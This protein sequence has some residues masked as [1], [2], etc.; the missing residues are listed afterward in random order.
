[1]S[2]QSIL[3]KYRN[4]SYS[5]R[6][7]G[8]R[9]EELISR[10]L[11]TDPAY[12]SILEKVWAWSTFP[13]RSDFGGRDAGIDLVGKTRDGEYWAFQCK[14]YAENHSVTK[15]DMDTFLSTSGRRFHDTDGKE[16]SFSLRVI[17]ATT[18]NW[19]INAVE[20]TKGQTIPVT[21]IGLSI[22]ENAPVDW[23]EI[24]AG[25]HG[26]DAR[27]KVHELRNHQMEALEAALVH[28]RDHNRGKMIM[29]CGTG[30][31][32]TSLRI[33]EAILDGDLEV[34]E[35]RPGCVLFLAPSISLVG[36]TLREWV[37]NSVNE[38]NAICVCSD[39]TVTKKRTEDDVGERVEDLGLP[40][41]TDPGKIAFRA[42]V[43]KDT[44]VVFSTYQSIDAV[45]AAQQHGLPEFDLIICDEAHRTTGV[46]ID[47]QDESSFTKVH[48]NNLLRS[49]RRLYM[50][51][52]PRL[53][54]EKGKADAKRAAVEICSMD[55]ESKYGREF[56][57]LN[58]GSAVEKDLLS[59]Y[60]VLILTTTTSDIPEILKR[61]W[62]DWKGEI[63]TDTNCKIWGCLN[64]LA[65]NVAYDTTLK[66]TDPAPMRS[67]AASPS[68]ACGR[69]RLTSR[70]NGFSRAPRPLRSASSTT[71]T[72]C[73][74]PT[75]RWKSTLRKAPF[76]PARASSTDCISSTST[77]RLKRS[78][79]AF[80]IP[81]KRTSSSRA[82]S[83]AS[84]SLQP[85]C[86]RGARTRRSGTC[87]RMFPTGLMSP[88]PFRASTR[89]FFCPSVSA[90][91]LIRAA[92][93]RRPTSS[94]SNGW[95]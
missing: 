49:K 73:A 7:K 34:G 37:S 10:Y 61:H 17:V 27:Q 13:S 55:D 50:T 22:L 29:A 79:R 43:S 60:K 14:C 71:R 48:D 44:T 89:T 30:K 92:S 33:A 90:T 26:K 59:D 4:Y 77:R 63:D 84:S 56:Y 24:E 95:S 68:S 58:F 23:D 51:A 9:F 64:A 8:T 57:T 76:F 52:T 46:I 81:S 39:T 5:E 20:V 25:V 67:A 70:P 19:S 88:R 12:A 36:Q 32:F 53:Y 93:R 86:A 3:K 28:Y 80:R 65:K 35:G 15:A 91:G 85:S 83:G 21:I 66:T 38:L 62:A 42:M 72:S 69:A 1:M 94:P 82:T 18:D 78:W 41:T 75:I 6:D 31:T 54:G 47:K 11:M 16:V 87:S 45:I 40:A 2:F 74:A